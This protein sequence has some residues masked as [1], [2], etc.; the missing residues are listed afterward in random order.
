MVKR[1][2]MLV[3]VMLLFTLSSC[4]NTKTDTSSE[5]NDETTNTALTVIEEAGMKN[6]FA[7][8]PTNLNFQVSFLRDYTRYYDKMFI[9]DGRVYVAGDRV[10]KDPDINVTTNLSLRP[11]DNEALFH[12]HSRL[13]SFDFNGENMEIREVTQVNPD[14]LADIRFMWYDSEYNQITI[15]DY[16]LGY[17]LHKRTFDDEII[18]SIPL[19]DMFGEEIIRSMVIGEDDNIYISN[20]YKLLIISKDGEILKFIESAGSWVVDNFYIFSVGSAHGKKPIFTMY[21]GINAVYRY[22]DWETD[23]FIPIEMQLIDDPSNF[24]ITTNYGVIMY[25]EGYDYYY[26]NNVGIYGYDIA[27]AT[28]T[29]VLDWM[30]SDITAKETHGIIPVSAEKMARVYIEGGGFERMYSI[31]NRVPDDEIPEKT[32]L[33]IGYIDP[34]TPEYLIRA[35]SNFNANNDFFRITMT[36]YY[37]ADT[38]DLRLNA[39]IA[40]GNAP[41][42][43][44]INDYMP[45]L[46]YSNKDMLVDLNEFLIEYEGLRDNLLPFVKKAAIRNKLT[47][48]PTGFTVNTLFGKT[49]NIGDKGT[50]TFGDML[51]MYKSGKTITHDLSK[52]FLYTY[53]L[54]KIIADCVDYSTASCDFDKQG[55]KDFIELMKLLPDSY[56]ITQDYGENYMQILNERYEAH[57]KDEI[58][59]ISNN[60][61]SLPEY[62]DPLINNFRDAEVT[63]IGYPTINGD[64]RG[65]YVNTCGF[66]VL[67]SSENI[68]VAWQFI[69]Y[70]LSDHFAGFTL[71]N[72]YNVSTSSAIDTCNGKYYGLMTTRFYDDFTNVGKDSAAFVNG[73]DGINITYNEWFDEFNDYI[74]YVEN[75][76]PKDNDIRNIITDELSDYYTANKNIDDVIKVIESRISV[77]LSEIWG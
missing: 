48:M 62:L 34:K 55:F 77:Y 33:S 12:V 71:S 31:L 41:D 52:D 29:K 16:N 46:S 27:T 61:F 14:I 42:L 69:M 36:N 73:V 66:S 70:C 2:C 75:Y 13:L 39:A 4:K 44:F 63:A 56:D 1:L 49:A 22:Y 68:D 11:T 50:W 72:G 5:N 15:E 38:P 20:N 59:L 10:K 51:E 23:S 21:D 67:N 58:L 40:G 45:L 6:V 3:L 64:V 76:V 60:V 57:R 32:Y 65:D 35:V 9:M 19:D 47:Y 24:S 53:A 18:F 7:E 37:N 17:T 74:K 30:N 54:D 8:T 28:L 26:L 43:L 25:G